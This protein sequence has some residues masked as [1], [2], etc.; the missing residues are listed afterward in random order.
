MLLDSNAIGDVFLMEKFWNT[1]V[2]IAS[3]SFLLNC[4]K[5]V[6]K[7]AT[8]TPTD[9]EGNECLNQCLQAELPVKYKVVSHETTKKP[10][11][12]VLEI[13]YSKPTMSNCYR[14]CHKFHGG[15]FTPSVKVIY[16]K[17]PDSKK[18]NRPD[19]EPLLQQMGVY[20]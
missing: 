12:E 13:D 8:Y 10:N 1:L 17:L 4:T 2:F 14:R 9:A 20:K 6:K 15:S 18:Q 7:P 16:D 5:T 19:R 3:V 11:W